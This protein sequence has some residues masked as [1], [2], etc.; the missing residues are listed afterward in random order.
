MTWER[1]R[2]WKP[3]ENVQNAIV[4]ALQWEKGVMCV[5]SANGAHMSALGR[6]LFFGALG[7]VAGAHDL[8]IL[9]QGGRVGFLEVKCEPPTITRGPQKGQPSSA[10]RYR[11]RPEQEEFAKRLDALGIP[12]A[13]VS[14]PAAAV[15]I[16]RGWIDRINAGL[17]I[18]A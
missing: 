11:L 12:W 1:R 16:V 7:G 15:A 8:C 5:A 2:A 3:E 18:A 9:M 14:D 10:K 17:E 4:G 6:Q 13:C